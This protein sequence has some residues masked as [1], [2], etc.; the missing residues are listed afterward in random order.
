M[1]EKPVRD[2]TA[3]P[4]TTLTELLERFGTAGGFTA[5]KLATAAGIMRRMYD[6]DCTVFLSF[7]ADIM[8]TGTRGVLQQLG[9]TAWWPLVQDSTAGEAMG[10]FMTRMRMR[11]RL[12]DLCLPILIGIY[13]GAQ[14]SSE[15]PHHFFR[16]ENR[17]IESVTEPF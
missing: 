13:L 10:A 16:V 7:P 5:T 11:Q 17:S 15:L 9:N 14:P 2:F 1:P 12:V 3:S 8:A 6:G 4:E